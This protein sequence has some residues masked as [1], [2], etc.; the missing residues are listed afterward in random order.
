MAVSAAACESPLPSLTC[1]TCV[2]C[3]L[4]L[5]PLT[6]AAHCCP[7]LSLFV[8][9]V[10]QCF[11]VYHTTHH[12][13]STLPPSLTTCHCLAP[14]GTSCYIWH[15]LALPYPYLSLS[16]PICPYLSLLCICRVTLK[17]IWV[18]GSVC[19]TDS[20]TCN[21]CFLHAKRVCLTLW[22]HKA[23]LVISHCGYKH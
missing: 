12:Y 9:T 22:G 2:H 16:V 18:D 13:R 10:A 23:A 3:Y 7:Y 14:S 4:S 21:F 19:V 17:T 8:T 20:A 1:I 15:Y 11:T 6:N 5:L